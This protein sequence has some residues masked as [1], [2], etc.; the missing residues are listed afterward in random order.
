MSCFF[1]LSRAAQRGTV[2]PPPSPKPLTPSFFS[3]IRDRCTDLFQQHVLDRLRME[4]EFPLYTPAELF[5]NKAFI[6]K[7]VGTDGNAFER[8]SPELR[9]DLGVVFEALRYDGHAFRHASPELREDCAVVLAAVHKSAASIQYSLVPID[10]RF[11]I[12]AIEQNPSVVQYI[13]Q[14]LLSNEQ[15]MLDALRVNLR[16]LKYASGALKN[17]PQFMLQA[18]EIS[19]LALVYSETLRDNKAFLEKAIDKD[20]KVLQ[21]ASTRLQADAALRTSAQM[22]T[23]IRSLSLPHG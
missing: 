4:G 14:D 22:T 19:E 18:I 11:M 15:F 8:A 7:A 6:W 9:G 23:L 1:S 5:A 13:A 20:P 12:E 2:S 16:V 21:Y 10:A 17:N 3:E